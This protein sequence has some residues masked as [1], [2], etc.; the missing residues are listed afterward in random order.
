MTRPLYQKP[1]VLTVVEAGAESL[2]RQERQRKK[3]LP[4]CHNCRNGERAFG[5][6]VCG[7]NLSWP[8]CK[9]DARGYQE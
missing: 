7:V 3:D 2:R 1:G 8:R 6:W 5:K 9:S 4:Q